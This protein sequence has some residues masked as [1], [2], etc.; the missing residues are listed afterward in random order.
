MLDFDQPVTAIA[1]VLTCISTIM[2]AIAMDARKLPLGRVKYAPWT[3][4]TITA[5]IA[6]M[7][8]LRNLLIVCFA[9]N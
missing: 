6:L 5:F 4:I 7:V 1:V 3:Y 2:I 9:K 8:A